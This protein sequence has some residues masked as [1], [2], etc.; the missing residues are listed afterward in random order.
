MLDRKSFFFSFSCPLSC[1]YFLAY[2]LTTKFSFINRGLYDEEYITYLI[3][4][5]KIAAKYGLKCFLDPHVD[6][7]SRFT[8]GSGM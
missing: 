4:L 6:C 2:N 3:S 1:T 5:L 7:W 8:G